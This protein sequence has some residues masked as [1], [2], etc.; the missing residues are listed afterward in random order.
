MNDY[1]KL[2]DLIITFESDLL[3][4]TKNYGYSFERF[5]FFEL[6][7][8]ETQNLFKQLKIAKKLKSNKI[9]AHYH[10][11]RYFLFT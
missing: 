1:S 4:Y 7:K 5:F 2:R 11:H 8:Y 9:K 3:L 10:E 6:S